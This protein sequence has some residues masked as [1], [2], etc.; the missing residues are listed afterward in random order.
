VPRAILVG[1]RTARLAT[2]MPVALRG[3]VVAAHLED[4]L[5]T[6]PRIARLLES[7]LRVVVWTVNDPA[8][9]VALAAEGASW[10]ITD[11]PRAI[12]SALS[13]RS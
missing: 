3:A 12:V 9:A 5:A 2:S 8:R 7:G 6:P 4:S 13:P 11:R 1:G 10:V